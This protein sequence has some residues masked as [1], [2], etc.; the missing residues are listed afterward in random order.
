MPKY[1]MKTAFMKG[2]IEE[3]RDGEK[4]VS[5]FR[6]SIDFEKWFSYYGIDKKEEK[7]C[8]N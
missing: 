2:N 6:R 8:R 5:F 3:R 1:I 4:T 7:E